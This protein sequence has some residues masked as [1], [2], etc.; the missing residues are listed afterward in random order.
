M[1]RW[2]NLSGWQMTAMLCKDLG[3]VLEIWKVLNEKN[4]FDSNWIKTEDDKKK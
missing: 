2:R 4:I 3:A 1:R